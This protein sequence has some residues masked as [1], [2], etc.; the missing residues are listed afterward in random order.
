[1]GR[2]GVHDDDELTKPWSIQHWG[3][4]QRLPVR[5]VRCRAEMKAGLSLVINS[6]MSAITMT[7]AWKWRL[8][9]NV[10]PAGDSQLA[11]VS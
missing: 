9:L 4:G 1:M 8:I 11:V 3:P 7:L 10:L 2:E 5:K 6:I